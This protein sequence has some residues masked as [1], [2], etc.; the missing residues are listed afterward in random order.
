MGLNLV[1]GTSLGGGGESGEKETKCGYRRRANEVRFG[2]IRASKTCSSVSP[3]FFLF[4]PH[5]LISSYSPLTPLITALK[6]FI[7][8]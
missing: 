7:D 5:F 8:M 4:F 6:F 2:G 3:N 1:Y